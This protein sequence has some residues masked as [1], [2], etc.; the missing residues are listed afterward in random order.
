MKKLVAS[1]GSKINFCNIFTFRR[2][3]GHESGEFYQHCNG[4]VAITY[5]NQNSYRRCPFIVGKWLS[6]RKDFA[7]Y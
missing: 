4:T 1:Q 7:C 5:L 6:L 2:E 3:D